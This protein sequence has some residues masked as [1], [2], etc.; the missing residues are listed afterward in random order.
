MLKMYVDV[1]KKNFLQKS[2]KNN[3]PS[4]KICEYAGLKSLERIQNLDIS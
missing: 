1:N 2:K 4:I 3:I